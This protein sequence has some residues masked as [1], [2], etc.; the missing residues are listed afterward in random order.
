[1]LY[2][3]RT[4]SEVLTIASIAFTFDAVLLP[5]SWRIHSLLFALPCVSVSTD[6]TWSEG[7]V[8]DVVSAERTSSGI[9]GGMTWATTSFSLFH[10]DISLR[11]CLSKWYTHLL[12]YTCW[13]AVSMQK[14]EL[15]F[16]WR[17]V[18][19]RNG[20][21]SS[22]QCCWWLTSHLKSI[23]YNMYSFHPI[24]LSSLS[25]RRSVSTIRLIIYCLS[26]TSHLV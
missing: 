1:M 21:S 5:R 23:W 8:H 4:P 6:T 13:R 9:V 2:G 12:E 15:M 18:K 22:V 14:R 19:P 10:T 25:F 7:N 17:M 16:L 11:W 20:R 26:F 3:N 24:H